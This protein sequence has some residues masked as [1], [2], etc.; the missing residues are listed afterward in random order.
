MCLNRLRNT[1]HEAAK[2]LTETTA[3]EKESTVSCCYASFPSDV[4][5]SIYGQMPHK[6]RHSCL[7]F[8]NVQP[9]KCF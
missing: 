9:C 6:T 1:P 4:S 5:G 8:M 2:V 3:K 7:P